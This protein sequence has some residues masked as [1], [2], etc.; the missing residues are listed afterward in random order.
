[1][2]KAKALKKVATTSRVTL[3]N[4]IDN[5][6]DVETT[7]TRTKAARRLWQ[8]SETSELDLTMMIGE[9]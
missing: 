7:T 2:S 8:A 9:I 1:M 4:G 6:G 3:A 5:D